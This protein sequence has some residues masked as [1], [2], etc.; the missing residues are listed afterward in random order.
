MSATEIQR[1]LEEAISRCWATLGLPIADVPLS[2]QEDGLV[3]VEALLVATLLWGRAPRLLTD[4]VA[5]VAENEDLLILQKLSSVAKALAA[6]EATA[7]T[8]ALASPHL[9]GFP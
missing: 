9:A 5:W 7:L 2:E 3:D 8:K 6:R 1:A 4:S